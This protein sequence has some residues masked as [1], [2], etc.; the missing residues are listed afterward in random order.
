MLTQ[1]SLEQVPFVLQNRVG[2]ITMIPDT[3]LVKL[4]HDRRRK[5]VAASIIT[6]VDNFVVQWI[7]GK[8]ITQPRIGTIN[9]LF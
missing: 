3:V 2:H 8:Q 9:T 6:P 7:P 1:S 4:S 5:I